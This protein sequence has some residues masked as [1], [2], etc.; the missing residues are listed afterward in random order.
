MYCGKC[1]TKLENNEIFCKNC[2]TKT[3]L[4]SGNIKTKN[5]SESNEANKNSNIKES[6]KN[7]V[8]V[9]GGQYTGN[10]WFI[11][12][13]YKTY[14][15]DVTFSDEYITFVQGSGFWNIHN[16]FKTELPYSSI[17]EVKTYKKH[18]IPNVIL[19]VCAVILAI[20]MQKWVN[21]FIA[22]FAIWIG[23]TAV[24]AVNSA[25]GNYIIP[26]EF[27]SDAEELKNKINMAVSQARKE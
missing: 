27:I 22:A 24:V 4:L 20:M 8:T 23:K 17:I 10:K 11:K 6:K 21:L 5:I 19:A 26:T 3:T 7:C 25:N 13:P 16:K 9:R 2:G 12:F 14:E 15:T 1:G 18:S